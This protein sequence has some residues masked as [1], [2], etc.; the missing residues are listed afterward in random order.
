MVSGTSHRETQ[1]GNY[2]V[3][4]I[5]PACDI[6][7]NVP[8]VGRNSLEYAMEMGKTKAFSEREYLDRTEV[9]AFQRAQ[10]LGIYD[11]Y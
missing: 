1:S 7:E 4:P 10:K 6:L 3:V 9:L 11:R 8:K 2:G 5:S